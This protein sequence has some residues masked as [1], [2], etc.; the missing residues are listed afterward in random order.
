VGHLSCAVDG[1]GNIYVNSIRFG[2]IAGEPPTSGVIALVS[3]DGS[4]RKVA[5]D[6]AFPNGMVITPDNS[7]L[8]ISES[9]AGRLTA[10]DIEADGSLSHRPS[11]VGLGPRP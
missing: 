6:L 8:I 7:M 2:F 5:D 10:F 9:F 4:A 1:R 3:P 11:C